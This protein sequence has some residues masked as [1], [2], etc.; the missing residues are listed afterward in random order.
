MHF[1]QSLYFLFLVFFCRLIRFFCRNQLLRNSIRV[2]NS[3]DPDQTVLGPNRLQRL[4]ADDTSRR[5]V[6]TCYQL[7]GSIGILYIF[8][9]LYTGDS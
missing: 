6:V 3:L 8:H 4:S 5:R 7:I 9:P 2:S 1:K